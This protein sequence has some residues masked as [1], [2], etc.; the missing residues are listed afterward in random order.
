MYDIE[1][2]L[3]ISFDAKLVVASL[4]PIVIFTGPLYQV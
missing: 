4:V 3:N 1:L 2:K